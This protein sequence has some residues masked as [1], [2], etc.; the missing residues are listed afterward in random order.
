MTV[1]KI[2][3]ARTEQPFAT[4]EELVERE[5]ID[6]GQLEEIRD[7][8][9]LRR[10]ARCRRGPA[11]PRW[12]AW[13]SASCARRGSRLVGGARWPRRSRRRGGRGAGLA[14]GRRSRA[15]RSRASP[16]GWRGEAAVLASGAGS[17]AR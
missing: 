3:A 2:V 9:T 10:R 17:V 8:V 7:L 16:S 15:S 4:L 11:R 14:S 12:R 13:P 5:V 6:R 1:Q